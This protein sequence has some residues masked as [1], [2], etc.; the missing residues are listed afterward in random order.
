MMTRTLFAAAAVA[1]GLVAAAPAQQAEAKVTINVGVGIPGGYYPDYGYGGHY[2]VIDP[3]HYG[4][5]CGKGRKIVRWNGFRRV[6]AV[7]C[8][9]PVYQYNAWRGGMAYR[10]KVSSSGHIIKVRPLAW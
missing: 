10:V 6:N 7:D 4:I 2:P 5:S 8:S 1:A 3:P 9:A